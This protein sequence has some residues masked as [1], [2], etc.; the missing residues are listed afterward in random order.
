MAL[1]T[2]DAGRL[3]FISFTVRRHLIPGHLR[4]RYDAKGGSPL[5]PPQS[6]NSSLLRLRGSGTGLLG[7]HD[8]S[9]YVDWSMAQRRSFPNLKPTLR[10][11]SLSP[12]RA[13]IGQL[14]VL[15]NKRDV[16]YQS[17]LKQFLAER[18]QQEL[19]KAA[20]A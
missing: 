9:D 4:P 11:I 6:V 16:P 8:S 3:L 14:K 20:G 18:L 17:L 19:S 1:G 15:A 10:T 5:C 2:A 12:S 7:H 13:M